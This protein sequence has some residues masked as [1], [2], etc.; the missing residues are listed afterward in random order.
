MIVLVKT[1]YLMMVMFETT[2]MLANLIMKLTD[3]F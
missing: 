1:L 2:M 3:L